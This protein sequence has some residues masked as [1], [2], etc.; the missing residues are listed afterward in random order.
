[1]HVFEVF[2]QKM[3]YRLLIEYDGHK[4]AGWQIQKGQRTVQGEIECVLNTLCK[5][6]VRITGGGRTDSG[7]HARGQTAHFD[8]VDLYECKRLQRSLNG[9]LDADIR[10]RKVEQVSSDFHAR[11]SAI[12]REYRYYIS[13][14]PVALQRE[15]CWYVKYYLDMTRMKQA[16]EILKK[17]KDFKS[18][19]RT[20]S[21]V[22][23]YLCEIKQADFREEN[24]MLVF[25]ISADRFLYG[26]V[27]SLVGALVDIGRGRLLLENVFPAPNNV[28][29]QSAP[30]RGLVLERIG[31]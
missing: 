20:G 18:F 3:R 22:N 23:H 11:Y 6:H 15:Y 14:K 31:Y 30:A 28:V 17:M 26:M 2:M 9:L 13:R 7:V 25:V 5:S 10:I 21:E 24:D 19:S 4:Y 16:A 29:W 1:M 12:E 27:R 8:L